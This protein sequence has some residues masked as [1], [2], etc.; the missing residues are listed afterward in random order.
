MRNYEIM[1]I[2]DPDVDERAIPG[3]VEKYSKVITD[4]KGTIDKTDIWGRRRL[5]YEINKKT[6]GFYAVVNATCESDTISEVD[7]LMRIDEQIMRAKV[8]RTDN[9]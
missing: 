1:M 2:I 4:D 8:M 5:A 6:D 3:I 9:K 7:R